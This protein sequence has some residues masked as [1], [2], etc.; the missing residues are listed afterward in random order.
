MITGR[1]VT[2]PSCQARLPVPDRFHDHPCP[3]C[4]ANVH[5]P[6]RTLVKEE[7]DA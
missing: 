6:K 5:D 2:C 7:A 1:K 4:G 3:H